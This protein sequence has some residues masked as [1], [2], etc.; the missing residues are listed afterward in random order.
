MHEAGDVGRRCRRSSQMSQTNA[1][2]VRQVEEAWAANDLSALDG[3]IASDLVS[4]DALPR[5]PGGLDGAK[6][7]HPM[8]MASFPVRDMTIKDVVADWDRVA[9]RTAVH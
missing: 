1:D 2:L 8:S 6:T 5:A 4:H 9:G 3:R 7:A